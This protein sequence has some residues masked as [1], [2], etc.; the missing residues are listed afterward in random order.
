MK[1]NLKIIKDELYNFYKYNSEKDWQNENKLVRAQQSE[2]LEDPRRNT[3]RDDQ[4]RHT[5]G[6][7]FINYG[8]HLYN[9][10]RNNEQEVGFSTVRTFF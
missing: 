8:S 4:R 5:L 3:R 6:E 1:V 2:Q 10:H 9:S 7:D